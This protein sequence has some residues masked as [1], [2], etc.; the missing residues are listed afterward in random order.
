MR[1]QLVPYRDVSHVAEAAGFTWVRRVGSH[2]VF[3]NAQGR[4][5]VIPD[6]GSQAIVRPLLRKTARD[7]GRTVDQYNELLDRL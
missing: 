6:H 5:I 1:L 4:T 3:R 2:N 7:M